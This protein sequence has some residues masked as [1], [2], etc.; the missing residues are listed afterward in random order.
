LPAVAS[1]FLSKGEEGGE[2]L[3]V[4]RC[5]GKPPW[6][7]DYVG[8]PYVGPLPA[9]MCLAPKARCHPSLGHRPRDFNGMM[10]SAEGAIPF[11]FCSGPEPVERQR[12]G[13]PSNAPIGAGMNRPAPAGLE[14]RRSTNPSP[15]RATSEAAHVGAK[16][17]PPLAGRGGSVLTPLKTTLSTYYNFA[18]G[19]GALV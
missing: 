8:S 7:Y 18:V 6:T 9:R 19:A 4:E 17:K 1:P 10:P 3:L 12:I 11:G 14:A 13:S 5:L 15:R 2:G 16:H